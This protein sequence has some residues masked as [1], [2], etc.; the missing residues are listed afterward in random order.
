MGQ[1]GDALRQ[2][3]VAAADQLFYKQGYENTSF[4][5]IATEVN[6]SRGN[7]YYHFKSK[8]D[9]L[10]AVLNARLEDIRT[11]LARWEKQYSDPKQCLT[12]F[13]DLL[14]SNQTDVTK[15]GCPIGSMCTELTKLNHGM[16]DR[17]TEIFTLFRDW[18]T[19]QFRLLGHK[20]NASQH[21]MHLLA[22]SQ[23]VASISNAFKDAK[24][25]QSEV[26]KLKIWLDE[27]TA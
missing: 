11:M 1:K 2:R 19:T 10:S 9:I 21:A 16:Q 14:S 8:D 18:L 12:R 13:I 23:G 24:F 20:Q 22:C 6:I 3:I 7:F 27:I 17:A 25:L 4:S 26:K 15:H 5:D